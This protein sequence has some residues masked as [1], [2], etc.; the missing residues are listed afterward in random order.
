MKLEDVPEGSRARLTRVM[1]LRSCTLIEAIEYCI[2]LGWYTAEIRGP[3]KK[4]RPSNVIPLN[5]PGPY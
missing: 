4:T 1:E 2:S 3:K 5:K